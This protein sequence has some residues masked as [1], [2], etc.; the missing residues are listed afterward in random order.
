[1]GLL[2]ADLVASAAREDLAENARR[3]ADQEVPEV[4]ADSAAVADQAAGG[5]VALVAARAAEYRT[6]FW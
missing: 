3:A 4:L 6:N 2:R 1:M 5:R